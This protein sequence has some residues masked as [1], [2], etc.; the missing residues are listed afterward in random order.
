[1]S[2]LKLGCYCNKYNVD[3]NNDFIAKFSETA[4]KTNLRRIYMLEAR[5]KTLG[6]KITGFFKS[7]QC[8]L[9]QISCGNH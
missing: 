2:L 4:I 9:E 3:I 8:T 7:P 5:V 1:M 6:H